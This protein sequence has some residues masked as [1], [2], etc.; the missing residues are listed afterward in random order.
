MT[1][2]LNEKC[3]HE[4]TQ[5]I[6]SVAQVGGDRPDHDKFPTVRPVTLIDRGN[7]SSHAKKAIVP[8]R[9][10]T[11][12]VKKQTTLHSFLPRR[13]GG[14]MVDGIRPQPADAPGRHRSQP[15]VK[16]VTRAP[17]SQK[18]RLQLAGPG[19]SP[20]PSQASGDTLSIIHL[21]IC[22]LIPKILEL[23]KLLH[24]RAIDVVLLQEGLV[25]KKRSANI[26]GYTA[27]RCK[28]TD[29]R[30]IMSYDRNGTIAK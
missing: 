25:G 19:K 30:G 8:P 5:L 9:K 23:S 12:S 22:G 14:Q 15:G 10:Q 20:C 6:G 1:D 29:C 24:E 18:A 21:N 4:Q 2:K 11:S 28:C 7:E 16:I 13:N 26:T 27:F 17:G 3:G